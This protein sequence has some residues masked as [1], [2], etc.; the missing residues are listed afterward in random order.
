MEERY[1]LGM[2]NIK[3]GVAILI[4]LV[5]CQGTG[6]SSGFQAAAA[7]I[8][9]MQ[10]SVENTIWAGGVRILGTL[11]GAVTGVALIIAHSWV[12]E[13][14]SR[15]LIAVGVVLVIYLCNVM[16]IPSTCSIAAMTFLAVQLGER[17]ISPIWDGV[18]RSVETVLGILVAY[19]V[20]KYLRRPGSQSDDI[21]IEKNP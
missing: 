7:S 15:L 9:C 1:K 10:P 14:V 17:E 2:R 21:K 12:P 3:T 13:P 6:L 19:L 20:N 11:I 16:K 5:I 4:C 18:Q 8:L